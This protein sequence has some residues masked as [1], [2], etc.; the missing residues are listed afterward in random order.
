MRVDEILAEIIRRGRTLSELFGKEVVRAALFRKQDIFE[1][2]AALLERVAC[3]P[4]YPH[5]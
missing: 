4:T 2:V 3:T 5:S 1:R